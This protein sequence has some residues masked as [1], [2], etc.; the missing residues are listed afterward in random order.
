MFLTEKILAPFDN[1]ALLIFHYFENLHLEPRFYDYMLCPCPIYLRLF[2]RNSELIL[3]QI[4]YVT[5]FLK[6]KVNF[7][8]I[9]KNSY[10]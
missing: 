9:S 8:T 5:L 4:K 7:H 2:F 6:R 3:F 1:I 10:M